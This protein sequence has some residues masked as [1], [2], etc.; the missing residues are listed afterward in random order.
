MKS[1]GL[2][3]RQLGIEESWQVSLKIHPAIVAQWDL[4]LRTEAGVGG[5][6]RHSEQNSCWLGTL[7]SGR[8]TAEHGRAHALRLLHLALL[9][10]AR[11]R[12]KQDC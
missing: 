12:R 1:A 4:A 6:D 2:L 5:S 11:V 3:P 10:Q 9:F 8:M 7:F